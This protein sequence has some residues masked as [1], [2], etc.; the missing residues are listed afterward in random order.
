MLARPG[1]RDR[2]SEFADAKAAVRAKSRRRWFQ[3][4]LQKLLIVVTL[5]GCGL[6]WLGYKVREGRQ[7]ATAVAAIE[8]LGGRVFYDYQVDSLG[9]VVPNAK[10]RGAAWLRGL[11]GNDVFRSVDWVNLA[12]SVINDGEMKHLAGFTKLK[13]LYLPNTRVTDV[14][15]GYLSGL[16]ALEMLD[17]GNTR[18]TDAGLEHLKG[19]TQLKTL[20]VNFTPVTDAGVAKLRGAVPNCHIVR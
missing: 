3:F 8:K 10:P 6:G 2:R 5:V 15:L 17:L 13:V 18:V 1:L 4:G 14:G 12:S 16:T 7:Q 19:L 9:H 20:Y 11:L